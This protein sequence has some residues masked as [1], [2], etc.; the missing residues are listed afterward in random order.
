MLISYLP[1]VEDHSWRVAD[2]EDDDNDDEHPG[3][4]LISP[5]SLGSS[6]IDNCAGSK[7]RS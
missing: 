6:P 3:N 5:G 2:E 1:R 7:Y 4:A